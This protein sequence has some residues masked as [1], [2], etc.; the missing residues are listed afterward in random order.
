[1]RDAVPSF[2]GLTL[3]VVTFGHPVGV[4]V[5]DPDVGAG[6]V[7]STAVL[8]LG[9]G[10]GPAHLVVYA[11]DPGALTALAG[12]HTLRGVPV[13]GRWCSTTTRGAP[14]SPRRG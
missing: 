5:L 3:T 1:M 11:R 10:T 9:T 2:L 6:E 13:P 4:T 7:G 12:H 14:S 8:P